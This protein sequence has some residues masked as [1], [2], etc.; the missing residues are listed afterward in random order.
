MSHS[1]DWTAAEQ[2]AQQI[3]RQWGDNEPGGVLIL[4]DRDGIQLSVAGGLENL[5]TGKAFSGKSIGRFA[6]IT[7]HFFCSMVL[8][9]GGL[10]KL[11]DRL[12][13]HLP[14]LQEPLASVTVAEA[15][16]M[17]GGLPDMRECLSLL[18]LSV[19][20]ET[21][22]QA[23]HDFIARQ[24][25]LNFEAG[26]EIS[27]SNT[28]YRLVEIIF[29]RKGIFLKD[30]L[31][32]EINS[33]LGTTFDAPH[34]W[35]DPVKDL[36]PG[37][38]FNGES[39]LQSNA[40]LQISA[41]GSIAASALDMAV[42]AMNLMKGEGKW[43]G[44]LDQLSASR[45]LKD[46]RLP[47]MVWAWSK[48]G[49]GIICSWGMGAVIPATNPTSLLIGKANAEWCFSQTGMKSTPVVPRLPQWQLYWVNRSPHRAPTGL[50]MASMS[51]K[52]GLS[53]WKSR[54]AMPSGWMIAVPFMRMKGTGSLPARPPLH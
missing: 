52:K 17:T 30:Y 32:K 23:N 42:W 3:A 46:G 50:Q 48:P 34:V 5:N 1:L 24:T 20:S 26:T 51:R 6:S 9:H 38:W 53:G 29:E 25:R 15:L 37:Y 4:F 39:W 41:S 16:D 27:Y 40:G 14:E 21:S 13:D 19:H 11:T 12:G 18:F 31:Q 33:A 2:A 28:G 54:A 45:H 49:W 44:L 8:A 35:A 36:A 7:K 10:V 43:A 47:V 22:Q